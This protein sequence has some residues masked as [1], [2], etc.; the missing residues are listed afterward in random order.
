MQLILVSKYS[1]FCFH[2]KPFYFTMY[3]EKHHS[4]V[5]CGTRSQIY[6]RHI[7]VITLMHKTKVLPMVLYVSERGV[8]K[9]PNP[10]SYVD[11][12]IPGRSKLSMHSR[13]ESNVRAMV[14]KCCYSRMYLVSDIQY[15]NTGYPTFE[16]SVPTIIPV[17]PRDIF[18]FLSINFWPPG[19]REPPY[20]LTCQNERKSALQL[21]SGYE[22]LIMWS[23]VASCNNYII[24][25][26]FI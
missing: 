4:L 12:H 1:I 8:L 14:G 25:R 22:I 10:K 16:S 26:A 2:D 9:G 5:W 18:S 15:C 17:W 13:K 7:K 6:M 3:A 23:L 20:I 21:Q 19:F 11:R 24:P